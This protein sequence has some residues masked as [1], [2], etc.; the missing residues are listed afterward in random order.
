[1]NIT[2]LLRR[3][4]LIVL[5]ICLMVAI[6]APPALAKGHS[7][8]SQREDNIHS[9][10][11]GEKFC[12]ACDLSDADLSQVDLSN[13]DLSNSMLIRANLRGTNL[14]GATLYG[15][16]LTNADLSGADLTSADLTS[17]DLTFANLTGAK[18]TFSQLSSTYKGQTIYPDG[19]V[20]P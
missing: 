13:A 10:K 2:A 12:F 18:V 8:Y 9:L 7:S 15:A 16:N 20:S 4:V 14:S 1:M 11:S 19:H 3:M 5:G 17:V 6:S